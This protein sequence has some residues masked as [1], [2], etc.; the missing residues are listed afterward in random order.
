MEALHTVEMSAPVN[1]ATQ[2]NITEGR[3][4]ETQIAYVKIYV[5]QSPLS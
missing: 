3:F 1:R 4:L 2:H 5:E